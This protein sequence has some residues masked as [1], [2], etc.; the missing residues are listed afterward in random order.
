MHLVGKDINPGTYR[1]N[2]GSYCYWE[3]LSGTSGEFDDII[4]NEA[5]E[6]AS[7]V[8]ISASD[9]AFKSQGCGKWAKIG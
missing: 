3:R 4:T 5:T 9:V 2:G 1:T 7:V 8:T 6:G